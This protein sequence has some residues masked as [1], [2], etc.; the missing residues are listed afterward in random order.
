[1]PYHKQNRVIRLKSNILSPTK[2][3]GP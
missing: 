2:F 3:S 1:M